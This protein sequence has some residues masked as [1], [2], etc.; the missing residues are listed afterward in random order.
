MSES[1]V[2][3]IRLAGPWERVWIF[4]TGHPGGTVQMP[5]DWTTACGAVAGR[6]R[7]TRRFHRPTN[8]EQHERVWLV[9]SGVGGN[10]LLTLN[11]APLGELAAPWEWNLTNFLKP[12]NELAIEIAF[13]PAP[14]VTGGLYAPFF[15]EIR[16]SAP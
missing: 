12:F 9:T 1:G 10:G 8:L 15:L 2:H 4:P 3:R 11:G 16:V 5:C 7:F 13:V 14:G 6:V